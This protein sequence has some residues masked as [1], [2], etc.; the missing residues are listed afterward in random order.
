MDIFIKSN[1]TKKPLITK[2]WPGKTVFPDFFNPNIEKF[3]NEGLEDYYKLVNY[4]GIWLDMNEPASLLKNS[5]YL[6]EILEEKDF[7][8]DKNKYNNEDLP[9]LPGFRNGFKD[10]LSNKSISENALVY[11]D[12]TIYDVK[13]L[14]A[15]YESKYTFDFLKENK[16]KRP[17]ILSRSTTLG[18][19]KYSF[20]WLG[21]NHSSYKDLK[22]SISGIFNFNIFGIPL[23]VPIYVAFFGIPIKIY[24]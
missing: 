10:I 17:F 20:H 13:P 23:V 12:L 11:G 4:D 9:Y 16:K 21:D 18:S 7:S 8:K 14:I 24:V 5:S 6:G 1:Y 2:V 3:W 19:G 15:F 22:Y